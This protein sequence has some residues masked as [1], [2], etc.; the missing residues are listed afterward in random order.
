[1]YGLFGY[2]YKFCHIIELAVYVICIHVCCFDAAG[3]SQYTLSFDLWSP[4][5]ALP[6]GNAARRCGYGINK[7]VRK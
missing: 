1:M 4:S 5:P 2:Y 3:D 6:Y 7:Y